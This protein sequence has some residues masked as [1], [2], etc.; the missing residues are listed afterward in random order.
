MIA[1]KCDEK[2]RQVAEDLLKQVQGGKSLKEVAQ[3][4]GAPVDE[5]GFFTRTAGAIPK[6]GPAG[7]F[8]NILSPLTEKNPVPK[9][10]LRTKDGYFVARLI[11]RW[12]RRIRTN[13][14]RRKQNLEKRLMAQKQEEFLQELAGA[15]KIEGENR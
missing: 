15:V 11:W 9:E 7:E 13:F 8:M 3:E 5:T 4:K 2:A 10:V 6:I 12:N 1:I 14:N